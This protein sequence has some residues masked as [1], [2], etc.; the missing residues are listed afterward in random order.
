MKT[1]M[2]VAV[3]MSLALLTLNSDKASAQPGPPRPPGPPIMGGPPRLAARQCGW[4][5]RSSRSR[6]AL[7]PDR[8][9]NRRTW[10]ISRSS[11]GGGF[12]RADL[13]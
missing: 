7:L 4:A 13:E 11:A 5:A 9:R 3:A 12:A 10:R 6:I 8:R 1:R 2:T